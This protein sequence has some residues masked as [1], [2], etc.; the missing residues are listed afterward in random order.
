[1]S[2]ILKDI[3]TGRIIILSLVVCLFLL[4]TVQLS[5]LKGCNNGKNSL[6]VIHPYISEEE[7]ISTDVVEVEPFSDPSLDKLVW[8]LRTELGPT[9][10]DVVVDVEQIAKERLL[11]TVNFMD[12]RRDA[13]GR[14]IAWEQRKRLV[15][16]KPELLW[17]IGF[18]L[19]PAVDVMELKD[20]SLYDYN[21][22]PLRPSNSQDKAWDRMRQQLQ[23]DDITELEYWHGVAN[24]FSESTDSLTIAKTLYKRGGTTSEERVVAVKYAVQ[25]IRENPNSFEAHHLLVLCQP[26]IEKRNEGYLNLVERFPN[27]SIALFETGGSLIHTVPEKALGYIQRA[28]LLDDRI[29]LNNEVLALCY[30]ELGEYEK[31]LAVYQ[32]MSEVYYGHAGGLVSRIYNVQ[33]MVRDQRLQ[34]GE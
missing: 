23:N 33:Q 9:D 26:S 34:Q 19:P 21:P 22:K 32:G 29:E 28:I 30:Y 8:Q 18:I 12:S 16:A 11:D 13:E 4:G 17:T 6:D 10:A 2:T 15:I 7:L 31:A 27:S 20:N 3:L 5:V 14:R 24:I 1:M 25:G